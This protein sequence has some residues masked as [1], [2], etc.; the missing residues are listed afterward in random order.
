MASLFY[1]VN[2]Y[3]VVTCLSMGLRVFLS[4]SAVCL[5]ECVCLW[6]CECVRARLCVHV[7]IQSSVKGTRV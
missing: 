7:Y 2:N 1:S 4:L 3:I 5:Y 6:M